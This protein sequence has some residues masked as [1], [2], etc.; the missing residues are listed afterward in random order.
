MIAGGLAAGG[1]GKAGDAV[2]RL[3]LHHQ[4]AQHIDAEALAALAVFRIARHGGGDMVVDPVTAALVVVIG[5]T[6][7][8]NESAHLLYLGKSHEP[9]PTACIAAKPIIHSL[10]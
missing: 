5:T 6:A 8:H 7:T 4:G 2:L 10:E 9:A 1:D 3:D